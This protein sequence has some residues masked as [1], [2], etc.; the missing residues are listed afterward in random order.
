[1]IELIK[2]N[3]FLRTFIKDFIW[4]SLYLEQ[5]LTC[6]WQ[7]DKAAKVYFTVDVESLREFKNWLKP[8]KAIELAELTRLG[9]INLLKLVRIYKMPTTWFVTAG[10]LSF[11]K[12]KLKEFG[13]LFLWL[14]ENA[15]RQEIACHTF[16]HLDCSKTTKTT[17]EADLNKFSN[18][19]GNGPFKKFYPAVSFA[20]PWDKAANWSVLEKLNFRFIRIK[21]G[22]F[23]NKIART[24]RRGQLFLLSESFAG[25]LCSS[26]VMKLG[27][28]IAKK[29]GKNFVILIH[30]EDAA[31]G[32]DWRQIEK[33]FKLLR[34]DNKL[35]VNTFRDAS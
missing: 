19:L 25:R 10:A 20:F 4:G 31:S 2:H 28:K 15:A 34:Q 7:K 5:C 23:P 29:T 6:F 11:G 16:N 17:L 32:K 30:P 18:L 12:D 13:H 26:W 8:P 3:F 33:L 1:M 14:T 9:L 24:E 35:L 21:K 22:Y 27:L